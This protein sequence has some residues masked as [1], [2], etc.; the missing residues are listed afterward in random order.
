M[1]T[2]PPPATSSARRNA[3]IVGASAITL[4]L[5]LLYPTSTNSSRL[6]RRPGQAIAPS[7]IVGPHVAPTPGAAAAPAVTTTIV[8]GTSIDTQYG[9]VQVQLAVRSG[10][11]VRATAID[12]PQDGGRSSEIN[13]YAIPRLQQETLTVRNA[14]IDTVSGA[15][16]TSAGYRQSLQAALDAAHLG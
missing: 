7:G 15:T 2:R 9:P 3:G 13:S 16:F 6:H 10:Q 12:Y 4:G 8:N 14:H 1:R 11:I 5:L